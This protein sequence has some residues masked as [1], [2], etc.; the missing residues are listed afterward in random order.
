MKVDSVFGELD[1]S[2]IDVMCLINNSRCSLERK[3]RRG[4]LLESEKHHSVPLRRMNIS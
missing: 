2:L 4:M 3:T 1:G